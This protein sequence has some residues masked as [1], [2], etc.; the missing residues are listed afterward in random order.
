MAVFPPE[1]ALRSQCGPVIAEIGA[2]QRRVAGDFARAAGMLDRT[3]LQHIGPIG[4]RQRERRH[5]VDEQ[6]RRSLPAQL[7]QQI[8]ED[9]QKL[10]RQA[11]RRLV[12]HE[13]FRASHKTAGN[14]EHLLLT[15]G[16]EAGALVATRLERSKALE[17]RFDPPRRVVGA[18]RIGAEAKIVDDAEAGKTCRPSGTRIRPARAMR[19]PAS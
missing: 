13:N 14:G 8:I 6:D 16:K 17:Q 12:E 7:R 9:F 1:A 10:R 2:Y 15:T 5:L 4:D 11:E 3:G 19:S 18:A